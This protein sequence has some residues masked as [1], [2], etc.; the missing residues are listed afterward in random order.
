MTHMGLQKHSGPTCW[1]SS[2]ISIADDKSTALVISATVVD[3]LRARAPCTSH[4]IDYK[5]PRSFQFFFLYSHSVNPQNVS[6]ETMGYRI[7]KKNANIQVSVVTDI[8]KKR[9]Y[10][11]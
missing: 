2:A 4:D 9:K 1:L 11:K 8:R 6:Y 10:F 7:D 5:P 3:I